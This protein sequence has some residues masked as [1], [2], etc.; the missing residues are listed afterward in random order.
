MSNCTYGA[1]NKCS[2]GAVKL[3]LDYQQRQ[4]VMMFLMGLIKKFSHIRD[5][6]LMVEPLPSIT[7]IYSLI[8]QEEKQRE[9]VEEIWSI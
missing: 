8:I 1:C 4:H 2:Y 9:I 7:K 6:I 3:F 5:Q